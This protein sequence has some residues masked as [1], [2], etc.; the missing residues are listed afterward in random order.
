MNKLLVEDIA[1][2]KA[3]G[4]AIDKA[5]LEWD[6]EAL[7]DVWTE[8]TLLMNQ[9]APIVKGREGVA[10]YYKAAE[11][12]TYTDHKHELLEVDGYGDIAYAR[13]AYRVAFIAEGATEPTQ[14]EGKTLLILRKQSD[15]RWR[16]SRFCWNSDL[17]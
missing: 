14:L 13:G 17:P 1:A 5:T 16:I 6:I 2:I 10:A 12:A 8:D 15:G 11:S 3:I 9:N 7:L 4:P